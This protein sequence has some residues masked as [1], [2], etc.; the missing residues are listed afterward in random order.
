MCQI[1]EWGVY[2]NHVVL[3]HKSSH[4]LLKYGHSLRIIYLEKKIFSVKTLSFV[5]VGLQIAKIHQ[6][7]FVIQGCEKY[8][9]L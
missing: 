7:R 3:G 1:F 2:I 4:L 6:L 9:H 5:F 8:I